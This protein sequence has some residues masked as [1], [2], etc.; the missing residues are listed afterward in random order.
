M[1]NCGGFPLA[2]SNDELSSHGLLPPAQRP[3]PRSSRRA[4]R[5]IGSPSDG[6][7]HGRSSDEGGSAVVID[8]RSATGGGPSVPSRHP[9]ALLAPVGLRHPHPEFPEPQ[10]P[11]FI[12]AEFRESGTGIA[13]S[14]YGSGPS[15]PW[16]LL[17]IDR[18][19][20]GMDSEWFARLEDAFRSSMAWSEPAP[21]GYEVE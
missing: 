19:G 8:F 4:E 6:N 3:N 9:S 11:G 10:N 14:E 13:F 1:T 21:A 12:V 18:P 7:E 2:F 15:E 5:V 17:L 20:Y 16:V